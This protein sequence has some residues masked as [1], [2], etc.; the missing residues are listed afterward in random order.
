MCQKHKQTVVCFLPGARPRIEGPRGNQTIPC[1]RS[2]SS[3]WPRFQ[4]GQGEW[5]SVP[6]TE[7]WGILTHTLL[8]RWLT[9]A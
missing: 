1:D 8:V 3:L 9:Q 5:L 7:A 4:I 6:S 2:I